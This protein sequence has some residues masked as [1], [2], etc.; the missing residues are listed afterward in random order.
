VAYA[1]C[2][3]LGAFLGMLATR[4]VPPDADVPPR[5]A[6]AVRASALVGA[7]LG[8]YLLELPADLL[9]WAAVPEP[10]AHAGASLLFGRTVLGGV[11][12]GW[13]A[14]EL[15]KR[16]LGYRG[17]TGDRFAVPLAIALAFGRIGC[18]LTGCCPGVPIAPGSRLARL[19]LVHRDPP[20]FPA[21]LFEAYFPALAAVLLLVASR[22]GALRGRRLAVY[23]TAYALVRF[24]LER[25]RDNARIALGLSYYQ[26]LAIALFA[27]AG[28]TWVRRS[29][30]VAPT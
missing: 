20:R 12:G 6:R 4:F 1:V 26:F 21:T 9:H 17:A 28:G 22:A 30:A 5:V 15:A 29:R 18:T 11:L 25:M 13:L 24:G 7:V 3:A 27:L 10:L 8:A 16:R 23:L 14:V 19:S 2:V